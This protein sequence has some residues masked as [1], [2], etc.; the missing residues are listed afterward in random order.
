MLVPRGRAWLKRKRVL[1]RVRAL[2]L[3]DLARRID[4]VVI[5]GSP[6]FDIASTKVRGI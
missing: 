6:C 5:L 2:G 4:W 3:G 1:G